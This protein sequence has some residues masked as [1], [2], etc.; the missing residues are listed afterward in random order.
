MEKY[1]FAWLYRQGVTKLK[2]RT[3]P[4]PFPGMHPIRVALVIK[5]KLRGDEKWRRFQYIGKPHQFVGMKV[6]KAQ[7]DHTIVDGHLGLWEFDRGG[8]IANKFH[9]LPGA[10][11]LLDDQVNNAL[12]SYYRYGTN[13]TWLFRSVPK[14]TKIAHNGQTRVV[15]A[16]LT[17]TLPDYWGTYKQWLEQNI[18]T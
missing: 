15:Y 1:D 3:S 16:Q 10:G 2:T 8:V 14:P 9:E 13:L 17:N 7:I 5:Y 18:V 4:K 12:V 11:G 6:Y